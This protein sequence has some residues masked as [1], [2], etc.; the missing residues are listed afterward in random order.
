MS[1]ELRKDGGYI[2][3]ESVNGGEVDLSEVH[4]QVVVSEEMISPEVVVEE[5]EAADTGTGTGTSTD[6][7]QLV[8]LADLLEK[9]LLTKDEFEQQKKKL[10]G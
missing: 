8:K 4:D 10:L 6:T 1:S 3:I 7:D 9:G 2:I 5:A